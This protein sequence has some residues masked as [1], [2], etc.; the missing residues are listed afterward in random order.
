MPVA[1]KIVKI[2]YLV[3]VT[4]DYSARPGVAVAPVSSVKA[5][6]ELSSERT[7]IDSSDWAFTESQ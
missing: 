2:S 3:A 1:S 6:V 5:S 4:A 7:G